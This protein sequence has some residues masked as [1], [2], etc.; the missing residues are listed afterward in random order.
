MAYCTFDDIDLPEKT[1]ITL[2]DDSVPITVTGEMLRTAIAGG[3][4]N[5]YPQA[6]Q[7]ATAA[8]VAVINKAIADV[9]TLIEA[10]VGER[11][12]LPFTAVP[13]LLKGLAV[14]MTTWR[15]FFRRNQ[16]KVPE[17]AQSAY[18]NAMKLL[19]QIRDGKLG[20]GVMP[21]GESAPVPA[22]GG[23]V[24]IAAATPTFTEESLKGF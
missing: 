14:D 23:Q 21:I 4:M 8:A 9:D 7:D 18:D 16:G 1:L 22:A 19:T 10:H 11:Y 13:K 5:G 6:A 20:I 12:T 17:A 15:L 24:R 3:D 2:I